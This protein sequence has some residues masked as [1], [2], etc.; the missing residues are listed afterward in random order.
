MFNKVW[1]FLL[2]GLEI[3]TYVYSAEDASC[4][5]ID[6]DTATLTYLSRCLNYQEFIK[7]PYSNSL[8]FVPFRE[9]AQYYLSNLWQGVTCGETV[10]SFSMNGQTELRMVY[11]LL[12]DTEASLEVRIV[13]LDRIDS[14]NNPTVVIRWKTEQSTRGWGLF[15][16]MMDKQVK[17]A[18]V[19][20]EAIMAADG[21]VAIEYFTVFNYEVHTDDCLKVDEFATT[22]TRLPTTTPLKVT[23]ST[24]TTSSSVTTVTTTSR[25]P[26]SINPTT[27]YVITSTSLTTNETSS[28]IASTVQTTSSTESSFEDE[29]ST[30][31]TNSPRDE[32]TT[33]STEII[34]T[35]TTTAPFFSTVPSGETDVTTP[36]S[37]VMAQS[38]GWIWIA[39]TATF[40][41]LFCLATISA[42]YIYAMNK[43]LQKLHKS[44]SLKDKRRR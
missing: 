30:I 21:D 14:D 10:Q 16:E 29:T 19:Q 25:D 40:A 42:V 4:L 37:V 3:R 36:E 8:N 6:F 44:Y 9:N 39:L 13:D 12:F 7:K 23:S 5:R 15:R 22:T 41:V 24:P 11:N 26:T 18:K 17:R 34:I 20:I 1:W 2:V 31:T 43:Q 35:R 33:H 32:T 38:T 28:S 27:T